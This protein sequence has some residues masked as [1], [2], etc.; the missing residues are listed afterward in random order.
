MTIPYSTDLYQAVTPGGSITLT[1]M[2]ETHYGSGTGQP[3]SAVTITI[4]QG[5]APVVGPTG[6]GVTSPDSVTFTYT[7]L[8]PAGTAPGD[9]LAQWAGTGPAGLITY[10]QGIIVALPP[11]TLPSPGVYA[12]PGQY[13][14]WS[15]DTQTPSQVVEITLRRASEVIDWAM[16][17]AA[18]ATD[19]DSMPTNPGIIDV[20]MRAT[21]AQCQF[22]LANND[23]ANVKS[24]Y[25]WTS[26]GGLQV[27]RTA[28]AQGQ[29]FPPLAPQAAA[30]LQ[31]IGALP[32]A[33]L[34]GW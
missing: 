28:T 6:T 2:F 34:I 18:Y 33:A 16:I 12:T 9:Y 25:A 10:T 26:T 20:F 23:P 21:C 27:S 30:I 17:S 32:G 24:Q 19:Q 31:T 1:Q 15:G 29:K 3:V 4:G 8:P 5:G 14:A 22:M 13:E 7:W 11:Q